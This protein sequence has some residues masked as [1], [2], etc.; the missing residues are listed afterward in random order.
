MTKSKINYGRKESFLVVIVA[1][2]LAMGLPIIML[3]YLNEYHTL[4]RIG[5]L[6]FFATVIIFIFSYRLDNSSMYD[7]YW[8]VI[9]IPIVA[10][11]MME[12][13]EGNFI[14]QL[15]IVFLVTFWGIRLTFN[16]VRGWPGLHHQDWR[17][18]DLQKKNGKAYWLVSF[19]GIHL[20]P[21]IL[22]FMG[23]IPTYFGMKLADPLN[24]IDYLAFIIAFGA[25]LI[26]LISDEQLRR[27]RKEA[28]LQSESIMNRGLWAYSRH[29]NYFG[30]VSF[31]VG[32][33]IFGLN[34]DMPSY[35]WVGIGALSMI[36]L[37]VFISIPMMDQRSLEK[38]PEY[39]EYMK[40]VSSL[41]PLPPKLK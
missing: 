22:V 7:P 30:E 26:E 8:S 32:L 17:Y 9:P 23:L 12:S 28:N 21:T 3:P 19:T 33:F 40:R 35:L 38:R 41:V 31:W 37:F 2:I 39:G 34:L 11:F 27:F 1:Y 25:V 16:W 15:M 18:V 5:I 10:Y 20:F 4:V 6:D 36:L 24:F 14:R 29:P 13:P